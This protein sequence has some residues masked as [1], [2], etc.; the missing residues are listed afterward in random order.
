MK[1]QHKNKQN[2]LVKKISILNSD[3]LDKF[4][5]QKNKINIRTNKKYIKYKTYKFYYCLMPGW[6]SWL[7]R[8]AHR[9]FKRA[10]TFSWDTV[11]PRVR[12]PL[13]AYLHQNIP[14]K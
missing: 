5:F 13:P 2:N 11:R 10:L 8:T 3:R 4:K 9:V 6:L 7:E 1:F 14:E 12:I